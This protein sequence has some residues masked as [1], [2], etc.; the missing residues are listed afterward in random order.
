M[1]KLFIAEQSLIGGAQMLVMVC[2]SAA[3]D[4]FILLP[5]L[6]LQVLHVNF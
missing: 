6:N 2:I 3:S 4:T 1:E 5:L